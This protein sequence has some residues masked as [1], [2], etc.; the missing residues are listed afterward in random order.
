IIKTRVNIA[1]AEHVY[2]VAVYAR[3][4]A[5]H[6]IVAAGHAFDASAHA[7]TDKYADV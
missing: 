3:T 7:V 5:V 1:D 6:S 4:A 2:I